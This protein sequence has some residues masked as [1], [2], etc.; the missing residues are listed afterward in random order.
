MFFF[1]ASSL[2]MGYR[3]GR[4]NLWPKY[5]AAFSSSTFCSLFNRIHKKNIKRIK[6]AT[7]MIVLPP[8]SSLIWYFQ[9]SVAQWK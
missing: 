5:A 1:L 9:W 2:T 6:N 3:A 7:I 4:E 8:L